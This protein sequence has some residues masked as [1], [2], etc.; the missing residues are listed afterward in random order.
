MKVDKNELKRQYRLSLVTFLFT[1]VIASA[2]TGYIYF[3]TKSLLFLLQFLLACSGFVIHAIYLWCSWVL[4]KNDNHER[5]HYH[6]K[7]ESFG[8]EIGLFV[9]YVNLVIL[10]AVSLYRIFNPSDIAE[11]TLFSK[12]ST[13][14]CIIYNCYLVTHCYNSVKK[15]G[16]LVMRAQLI[17]SAKNLFSWVLCALT[18]VVATY[19]PNSKLAPFVEPVFCILL[20]LV[21]GWLNF[22]LLKKCCLDLLDKTGNHELE[23]NVR[24]ILFSHSECECLAVSFRT[25]GKRVVVDATLDFSSD[26]TWDI[27]CEKC[28][29][30]KKEIKEKYP[31]CHMHFKIGYDVE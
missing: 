12:V 8:T 5:A 15:S 10:F 28:C 1:G 24:Q 13:G 21:V 2:S 17:E 3:T 30:L 16:N 26:A 27:M 19:I 23:E 25:C 11:M 20:V 7:L 18:Q 31:Q 22:S 6:G 4:Y 14:V 9:M 29:E